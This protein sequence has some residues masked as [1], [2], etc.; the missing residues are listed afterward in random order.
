MTD[1]GGDDRSICQ[2]D[3]TL[4]FS[5]SLEEGKKVK[6]PKTIPS[7][8]F[9]TRKFEDM[10]WCGILQVV[11]AKLRDLIEKEFPGHAQ[12]VPLRVTGKSSDLEFFAVNWLH[13]VDCID[14]AKSEVL[15]S[16]TNAQGDVEYDFDRIVIDSKR[17]PESVFVY[18]LRHMEV[19][20][21][22]DTLVRD[23][24]R[25]HKITGPQFRKRI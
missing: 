1:G 14:L 12:F 16:E 17:V 10:P 4:A 11:S 5:C 15:S 6:K 3:A 25:K 20:V 13:V 18:R 23:A 7:I 2:T 22:C 21:M 24:F 19:T 9:T 8:T